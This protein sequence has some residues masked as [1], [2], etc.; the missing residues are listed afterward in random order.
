MDICNLYLKTGF[1]EFLLVVQQPTILCTNNVEVVEDN[2]F[3]E[4]RRYKS[5]LDRLLDTFHVEGVQSDKDFTPLGQ[6]GSGRI[7][8]TRLDGGSEAP[9]DVDGRQY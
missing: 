2:C 8:R 7:G 4:Q 5:Q 9:V 6:R 1:Q 3:V